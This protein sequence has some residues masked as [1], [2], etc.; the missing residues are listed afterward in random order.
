MLLKRQRGRNTGE[1]TTP[2]S[3]D[4]DERGVTMRLRPGETEKRT[5]TVFGRHCLLKRGAMLKKRLLEICLETLTKTLT[6]N[7]FISNGSNSHF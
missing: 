7:S 2:N 1:I 5:F 3:G 6:M 4:G